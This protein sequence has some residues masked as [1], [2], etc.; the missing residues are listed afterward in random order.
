MRKTIGVVLI[1]GALPGVASAACVLNLG[2]GEVCGAATRYDV[3]VQS[4][5]LCT[6]AS[7][8]NPVLV[9]TGARSF[10]IASAAV[11][12]AVG[13]YANMDSVSGGTYT[14]VRTI[15]SRTFSITGAAVGACAA[16][17]AASLSV[18][19][20]NAGLDAAMSGA[21]ITWNDAPAKSQLRII[22]ALAAPLTVSKTS[23]M[24]SISVKFG[25]ANGV[26]CIAGTAFPAPPDVSI[27]AQ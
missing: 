7:C 11:G 13:S 15:V 6:E 2:L 20:D 16:Q 17:S 24:P 10:D 14:H 4:V 9:G 3:S 8:A 12:A 26:M 27:T 19:N 21:G 22:S 25:T 18:P 5:A 1:L 23:S